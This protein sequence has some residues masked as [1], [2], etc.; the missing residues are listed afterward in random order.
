M[1]YGKVLVPIGNRREFARAA[2]TECLTVSRVDFKVTLQSLV[3][4][5]ILLAAVAPKWM[6]RLNVR[7]HSRFCSEAMVA[8][9]T[10]E[11]SVNGVAP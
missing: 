8:S 5:E 9:I 6:F 1:R 3:R 2:S 4:L 7:T 10:F 11:R